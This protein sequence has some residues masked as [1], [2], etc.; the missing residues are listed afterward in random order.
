MWANKKNKFVSRVHDNRTGWEI[1]KSEG[2]PTLPKI[3]K[4]WE[5]KSNSERRSENIEVFAKI[6]ESAKE[7]IA[8]N[9]YQV[10]PVDSKSYNDRIFG[11]SIVINNTVVH[12]MNIHNIQHK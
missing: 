5:H 8:Q 9:I 4:D 6:N 3:E 11:C 1:A 10:S 2:K 7:F 12:S